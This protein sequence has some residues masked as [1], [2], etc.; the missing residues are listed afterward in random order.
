MAAKVCCWSCSVAY[1]ESLDACPP[2]F[3]C[4]APRLFE[5]EAKLLAEILDAA[6]AQIGRL[7]HLANSARKRGAIN[8]AWAA[9]VTRSDAKSLLSRVDQLRDALHRDG[10]ERKAS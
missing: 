3:G 6:R 4:G 9:A 5:G 7:E 10:E 2:P 8:L 1:D